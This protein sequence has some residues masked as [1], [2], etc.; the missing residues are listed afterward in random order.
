VEHWFQACTATTR[1]DF[2]TILANDTAAAA[3]RA[4]RRVAL[5]TDWEQAKY[6][7]MLHGLRGKFA[8]ETYRDGLLGSAGRPLAEDSPNFVWGCRDPTCGYGGQNLLGL[9]L[10]HVRAELTEPRPRPGR[11]FTPALRE[12]L[13]VKGRSH[14]AHL[15]ERS[16]AGCAMFAGG[17]RGTRRRPAVSLT[18]SISEGGCTNVRS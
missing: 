3:K 18:L 14:F 17:L 2:D 1:Q 13:W 7:V 4:G 11:P 6:Q 10:M 8:V 9:A 5:R 12:A 16:S 15:V